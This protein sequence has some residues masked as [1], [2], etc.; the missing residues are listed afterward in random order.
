MFHAYHGGADPARLMTKY[1][2]RVTSLHLKDMKKGFPVKAG[3]GTAPGRR[4]RAR[5]HGPDRLAGRP[6]RRHEGGGD[7]PTTSRTR[8]P[9]RSRHIPQSLA[10]LQGLKL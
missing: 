4:G 5:G 7:R 3:K 1:K 6:A 9:I 10:Y 2:G 8:A